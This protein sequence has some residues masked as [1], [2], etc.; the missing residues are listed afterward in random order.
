MQDLVAGRVAVVTGGGRGIGLAVVEAIAARGVAVLCLDA[1]DAD[2]GAFSQACHAAGVASGSVGVDVRDQAGVHAA[3]AR[4][5]ELGAGVL[6]RELR[7]G[8]R[9][10]GVRRPCPPTSGAGSSTSTST[11]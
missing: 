1:P 2:F 3:V 6:R 5:R 8:R 10:R 11:G 4:A 7:G 9:A